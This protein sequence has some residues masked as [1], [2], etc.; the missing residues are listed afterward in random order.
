M[1]LK[2]QIQNKFLFI[3]DTEKQIIWKFRASRYG[4]GSKK[5]SNGNLLIHS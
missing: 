3:T 2:C 5:G 1:L 4:D